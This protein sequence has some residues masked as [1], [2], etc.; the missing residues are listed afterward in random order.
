[1]KLKEKLNS[2]RF[3]TKRKFFNITI[4]APTEAEAI[5]CYNQFR[6]KNLKL[7]NYDN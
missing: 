1:M 2:Y 3:D 7:K 4:E 5:K 6:K